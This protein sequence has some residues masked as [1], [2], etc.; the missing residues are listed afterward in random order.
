METAWETEVA[1]L[2]TELSATQDEVLDVLACKRRCLLAADTDGLQ[3]LEARECGVIARLEAC[4]LRRAELLHKAQAEGLPHDSIRS[5]TASLPTSG[6]R[7][8][9]RRV[10]DAARRASMLSHE[11]LTNWVLVQRTLI[12]L[13]HLLEIIATGGRL[14]PTYGK[15]ESAP[16]AGSLVDRAA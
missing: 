10:D 2:L 7:E 13:A 1:A 8:L 6:K 14:R 16:A 15:G 4:Q 9:A 5:L 11:S 3:S 12:H